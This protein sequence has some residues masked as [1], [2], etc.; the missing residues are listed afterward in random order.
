MATLRSTDVVSPRLH[1]RF[2]RAISSRFAKEAVRAR[3]L[4]ALPSRRIAAQFLS[5]LQRTSTSSRLKSWGI[6]QSQ[7][8]VSIT[9]RCLSSTADSGILPPLFA[10]RFFLV[11]FY[12]KHLSI[13][14]TIIALGQVGPESGAKASE[15]V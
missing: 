6:R 13:C 11:F 10:P 4:Q 9:R 1:M 5:G 3:F 14:P 12:E 7:R 15:A 8:V 2:A